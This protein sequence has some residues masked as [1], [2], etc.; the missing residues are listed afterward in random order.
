[1]LFWSQYIVLKTG[2]TVSNEIIESLEQCSFGWAQTGTELGPL[3]GC[4]KS[5]CRACDLSDCVSSRKCGPPFGQRDGTE[6]GRK[7]TVAG[8]TTSAPFCLAQTQTWPLVGK[9]RKKLEESLYLSFHLGEHHTEVIL[10]VQN[11]RSGFT[12]PPE[13]TFLSLSLRRLFQRL[14]TCSRFF[15]FNLH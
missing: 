10:D 6:L 13:R 15:V 5:E 3:P 4:G 12:R 9:T 7:S 14:K 8:L 1:M 11:N 2:N